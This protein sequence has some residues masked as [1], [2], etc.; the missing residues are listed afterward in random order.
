MLR[1]RREP[2]AQGAAAGDRRRAALDPNR[3]PALHLSPEAACEAEAGEAGEAGEAAGAAEESPHT[4]DEFSG[5]KA[6]AP[7]LCG[8]AA[9]LVSHPVIVCFSSHFSD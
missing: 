8:V 3:K 9:S 7:K 4:P 6:A 5:A 1:D 2:S